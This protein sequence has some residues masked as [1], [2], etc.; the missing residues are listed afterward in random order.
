MI[1]IIENLEEVILDFH[2]SVYNLL[3]LIGNRIFQT[4]NL[5]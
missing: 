3:P 5:S 1:V 2:A 4:L